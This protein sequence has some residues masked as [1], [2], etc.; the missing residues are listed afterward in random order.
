M[1]LLLRVPMGRLW[2][3]QGVIGCYKWGAGGAVLWVCA[4]CYGAQ[5]RCGHGAVQGLRLGMRRCGVARGLLVSGATRRCHPPP[6]ISAP[7][8]APCLPPLPHQAW[9]PRGRS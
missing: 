4:Q 1:G 7:L 8:P 9:C 6:P 3:L 2:G 5:R